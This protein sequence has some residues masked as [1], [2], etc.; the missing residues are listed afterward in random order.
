MYYLSLPYNLPRVTQRVSDRVGFG[1]YLA[2]LLITMLTEEQQLLY[3]NSN[4]ESLAGDAGE[5]GTLGK[6]NCIM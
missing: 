6:R 2:L 1:L 4:K 3:R 5:T